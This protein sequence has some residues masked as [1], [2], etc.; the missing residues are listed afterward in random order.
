MN[1]EGI[2]RHAREVLLKDYFNWE[3]QIAKIGSDELSPLEIAR[4]TESFHFLRARLGESYPQR[5][6]ESNHAII[7]YFVNRAPWTRAWFHWLAEAIREVESIT[8][9]DGLL[10]KFMS[11]KDDDFYEACSILEVALKLK[12]AGFSLEIDANQKN[13]NGSVK[14][15]DLTL[16]N[17]D[18]GENAIV[19]VTRLT[20]NP[21]SRKYQSI[22]EKVYFA[23]LVK[24]FPLN[25]A[26]QLFKEVSDEHLHEISQEIEAKLVECFK[27]KS[28][29]EVSREGVIELGFA[30]ENNTVLKAW[31]ESKKYQLNSFKT[32]E[33]NM[34]ARVRAKIIHKKDQLSS[35]V[36]GVLVIRNEDFRIT[37]TNFE[38][39]QDDLQETI[40][41]CPQLLAVVLISGEMDNFESLSKTIGYNF[42]LERKERHLHS[43][44]TLMLF[45]RFC[46]TKV[47]PHTLM[48]IFDAFAKH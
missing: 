16:L 40:H 11:P 15:P 31:V 32:P 27:N 14:M 26:G 39:I 29:Q 41:K 12:R 22:I 2:K 23:G 48:R 43:T 28:F 18:T 37:A 10:K 46:K 4:I 47:T 38:S 13:D 35:V 6:F 7:Q 42:Y 25:F 44:R 24:K 9:I 20:P 1:L 3:S 30:P 17:K 34:L 8:N 21:T 19:E 5:C 36:P 33:N 45:N